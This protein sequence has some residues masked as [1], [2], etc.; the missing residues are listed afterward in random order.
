MFKRAHI[1]RRQDSDD[2]DDNRPANN[3]DNNEHN[4][5]DGADSGFLVV[6]EYLHFFDI[7]YR[8]LKPE[9]ILVD[10]HGYLKLPDFGLAK[11]I[12]HRTYTICGTPD[13]FSPEIIQSKGHGKATDW[14]TLGARMLI[15]S[16]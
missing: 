9:N 12:Q 15:S 3:D 6:F 11:R 10:I 13:Y 5:N 4:S 14:W 8:D 7:I 2:E 16:Y 1:R